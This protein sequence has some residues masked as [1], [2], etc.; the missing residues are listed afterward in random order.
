[1]EFK[2]TVGIVNK[3][4]ADN[5]EWI[6]RYENYAEL[7]N[8]NKQIHETGREK[9]R[10]FS[11][12]YLYTSISNLKLINVLNYD[13]RFLGQSIAKIKIKNS[14][15]KITTNRIKD[16]SNLK[17]F[18][19]NLPLKDENWD[20]NKAKKFRSEFKKCKSIRGHSNEHKIESGLLSEFHNKSKSKKSLSNIQP[21][22]LANSFFQMATPFKASLSEII[23]SKDKGGGIDILA[24]VKHKN[25]SVRLCVMELKDEYS[26]SEPP[27]KVMNQAITYSTFIANLLRSKSGN[28][29]YK[30]FGFSG[31]VPEVLSIDVSIVLP[32]PKKGEPEDFNKKRIEV[33]EN[34]SIELYSLYFKEKSKSI[35]GYNYEFIGSL[36]EEMMK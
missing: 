34:T 13:L 17:H 1:M 8:I 5:D 11:P 24:R 16:S 9:F 6:T 18:G 30:I 27:Q 2:E 33:L 19:I 31:N 12:L 21:V 29:W 15:V 35:D 23:Y 25:N 20:G 36:K 7:I 4:L 3:L 28:D 32:Y 14:V 26:N 10:I 22:L